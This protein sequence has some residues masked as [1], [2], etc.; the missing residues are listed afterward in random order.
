MFQ[1]VLQV[2]GNSDLL[3]Q[4]TPRPHSFWEMEREG[5]ALALDLDVQAELTIYFSE[6]STSCKVMVSS[7]PYKVPNDLF[8][9]LF[10]APK[11]EEEM[12]KAV[13][14]I[15][16]LPVNPTYERLWRRSM[17]LR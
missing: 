4:D 2:L 13:G 15:H 16:P 5:G 17:S 3:G 12:L 1:I 14:S 7:F 9:S 10:K 8:W 6:P 11:V